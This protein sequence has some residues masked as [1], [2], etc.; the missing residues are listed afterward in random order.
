MTSQSLNSARLRPYWP[1]LK[2]SCFVLVMSFIA[3]RAVQLWELSPPESFH[4]NGVWLIPAGLIYFAGWLPSV[5]FWRALLR[6]MRQPLTVWDAIRAYYVGNMGKYVPGK[7]MVLVIR[8]SMV[9]DAGGNS[10]LAGVTAAYETLVAM[11]AGGMLG[12]ALAPVAFGEAFWSRLP[13][14]MVWLRGNPYLFPSLVV[15]A[16]FATT[17]ISAWIFTKVGRKTMTREASEGEVP[18]AIS[19]A[20]ISN[21]VVVTSLGWVCHAFSLGFVIQSVSKTPFDLTGFPTWLTACSLSIVGGFVVLF[22]PGGLGVREGILIEALKD[23][24]QIG[25]A[26]AV[27]VAG[28]LRA[29]WF[30]TELIAAGVLLLMGSR[31]K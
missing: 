10:M 22:A 8:G 30:V 26:M 27:V 11:A 19:A 5:W 29:V 20:L 16:T 21:G 6:E 23:Q 3:R 18:P 13:M 2:W 1:F 15:L 4:I 9:K 17:P 7:A 14:N 28:L 31:R 12:L 24:P 25:P